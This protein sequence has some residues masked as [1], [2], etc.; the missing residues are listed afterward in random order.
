MK[1]FIL[2]AVMIGFLSCDNNSNAGTGDSVD[3]VSTDSLKNP[4]FNPEA[5]ADSTAKQMNLDSTDLQK[6]RKK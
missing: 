4:S 6:N 5:E 1:V 3:S 2:V